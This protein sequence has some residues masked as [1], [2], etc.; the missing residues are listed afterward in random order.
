MADGWVSLSG[1]RTN[2]GQVGRRVSTRAFVSA[3][4]L[5]PGG[6]NPPAIS[7]PEGNDTGQTRADGH[8]RNLT[9]LGRPD[10]LELLV[11]LL[12]AAL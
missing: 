12:K 9:V 4:R 5:F 3:G 11:A 6:G 8:E 1:V 2:E 7:A 10:E